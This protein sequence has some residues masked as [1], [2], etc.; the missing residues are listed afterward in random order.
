[1]AGKTAGWRGGNGVSKFGGINERG[2]F[3]TS[4]W[5]WDLM[6][7]GRR[8][9]SILKRGLASDER[10]ALVAVFSSG[11]KGVDDDLTKF[12]QMQLL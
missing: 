9:V 12:F 5:V 4:R 10:E 8:L 11:E 1:M 3:L 6:A 7:W 2:S